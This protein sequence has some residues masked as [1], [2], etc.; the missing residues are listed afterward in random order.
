MQCIS[1][2][3]EVD[4]LTV[5]LGEERSAVWHV[6]GWKDLTSDSVFLFKPYCTKHLSIIRKTSCTL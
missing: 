1:L 5:C 6:L 4:G 3:I 2:R